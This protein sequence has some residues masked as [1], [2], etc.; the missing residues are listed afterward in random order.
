[1]LCYKFVD[2]QHF[3]LHLNFFKLFLKSIFTS[4]K[5]NVNI[6]NLFE[7]LA[8]EL[9]TSL[10]LTRDREYTPARKISATPRY[11]GAQEQPFKIEH[12]D[13]AHKGSG[14]SNDCAC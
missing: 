10:K 8:T 11:L 9:V 3:C 13:K 6:D 12:A 5:N 2:Q 14:A 4:A 1:M 7:T